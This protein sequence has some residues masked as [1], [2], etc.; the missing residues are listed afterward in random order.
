[1]APRP[2]FAVTHP[3]ACSTA[4]ER[5]FMTR[6]DA[7]SSVHEPFG[8]AFY[9]G[10]ESMSERYQ[11]DDAAREASGFSNVTYRDIVDQIEDAGKEGKR[12]FIKDMAQY[13][14]RPDGQPTQV[15]PSCG[16][17]ESNNP[18]R[19]P[20]NIL[21]KFHFTFLIRHPRRSIPSYYRC[22]V[23]PLSKVTGF[24]HFLPSEAGYEELVRFFD[25][26]IDEGL[27]DKRQV[28][29]IDAD[30]LLDKPEETIR[31]YCKRTGIDFHP[32]MLVWNEE[33]KQYA[34]GLFE[35]WKGFHDDAIKSDSLRAR[36]HA[37]KQVSAEVD[38]QEWIEKYGVEGQKLIRATV[39][40]NVGYY[41]YLRQF[42]VKV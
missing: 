39:D 8:D 27:V 24:E 9:Y 3:R 30:D 15:A 14:F 2:I 6:R 40:A 18:T 10:P 1:M 32:S 38:D 36:T 41:E 33:D 26:V 16:Q 4:F 25:F 19:L 7:M 20:L 31:A 34:S 21:R 23:P 5:V 12:V 37:Q 29:V 17:P 28:T 42:C 11:D 35:K 22:T 13:L